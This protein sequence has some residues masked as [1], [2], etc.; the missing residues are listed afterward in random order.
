MLGLNSLDRGVLRLL[1]GDPEPLPVDQIA[2]FSD[3]ERTTAFRSV[4]WLQEAELLA[5]TGKLSQGG[6]HHIESLT[7]TKSRINSTECSISRTN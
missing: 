1:A 7:Q 3:R 2:K 4:R 5:R 6:Y